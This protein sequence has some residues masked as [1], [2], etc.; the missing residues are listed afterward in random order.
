[1][2]A[3]VISLLNCLDYILSFWSETMFGAQRTLILSHKETHQGH[4]AMLWADIAMFTPETCL[5]TW[6]ES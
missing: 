5:A 3:G 4:Q 1:M 2:T 6:I